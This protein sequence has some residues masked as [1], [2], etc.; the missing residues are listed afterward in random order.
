MVLR[1]VGGHRIGE[2]TEDLRAFLTQL[3]GSP[4]V[5]ET[6]LLH[7][8]NHGDE[9][10]TWTYA[11]ADPVTGVAR[12]RC[13]Q[14]ATSTWVLD[15]EA[16]WTFPHVWSCSA[17]SQSICEVAAGMS[18]PDDSSVNWLVLAARCVDCGRIQGLT[19]FVLPGT[20]VAEVM[21]SI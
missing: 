3:D 5:T 14:C 10:P 21:G 11:E 6:V 15:S 19:D 20:S 8:A 17:C 18:M 2:D 4:V 7:C 16:R 13:L 1:T 12:R 9:R